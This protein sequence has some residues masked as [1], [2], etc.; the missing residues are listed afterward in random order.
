MQNAQQNR[1]P[2]AALMTA[3]TVTLALISLFVPLLS[4]PASLVWA[5][6]TVILGTRVGSIKFAALSLVACTVLLTFAAGPIIAGALVLSS[7]VAALSLSFC[8]NCGKSSVATLFWTTLTSVVGKAAAFFLLYILAGKNVLA[9][10][11]TTA[12]SAFAILGQNSGDI[13][14]HLMPLI[15]VLM[16]FLETIVNFCLATRILRQMGVMPSLAKLPPFAEWKLPVYILYFFVLSIIGIYWGTTR[17]I[18]LLHDVSLNIYLGTLLAGIT[19]G[20]ALIVCAA[21]HFSVRKIWLVLIFIVIFCSGLLT[22]VLAFT[23]L[24][25]MYFDYRRRF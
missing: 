20:A 22:M 25:D 12:E 13:L 4:L 23:G 10:A 15:I 1:L 7:G 19:E 21:K 14:F 3:L 9:E 6:P 5:L 2:R 16:A 17:D 11:A 18:T 24:F 8:L